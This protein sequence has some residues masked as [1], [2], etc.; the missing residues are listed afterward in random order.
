MKQELMVLEYREAMRKW[1]CS[2]NARYGVCRPVSIPEVRDA[3]TG[4]K[5]NDIN[6]SVGFEFARKLR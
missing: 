2:F 1:V 4:E 6:I 3:E 5:S